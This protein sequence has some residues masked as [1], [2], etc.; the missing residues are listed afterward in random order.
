[1][2]VRGDEKRVGR[3]RWNGVL[4]IGVCTRN[5]TGMYSNELLDMYLV[6]RSQRVYIL[7]LVLFY[8]GPAR[9]WHDYRLAF[10]GRSTSLYLICTVMMRTL[11][12]VILFL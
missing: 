10:R 2:L 6:Y 11:G 1:M 4:G 12:P 8:F 7:D 9:V 5:G 3:V